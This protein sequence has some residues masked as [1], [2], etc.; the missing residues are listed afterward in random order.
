M[1]LG[2]DARVEDGPGLLV[3]REVCA[4]MRATVG[5]DFVAHRGYA[6]AAERGDCSFLETE[7][8]RHFAGEV[9]LYVDEPAPATA[10]RYARVSRTG[11][12]LRAPSGRLW[13][14]GVGA[15]SG[16]TPEEAPPLLDVEVPPGDCSVD[17]YVYTPHAMRLEEEGFPGEPPPSRW[18]APLHVSGCLVAVLVAAGG[19]GAAVLAWRGAAGAWEW[20]L[21][22]GAAL[23]LAWGLVYR[24]SGEAS[25]ERGREASLRRALSELPPIPRYAI[26]VRTG[27]IPPADAHGGGVRG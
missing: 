12:W 16:R 14:V 17:L 23:W 8:T 20:P 13:L 4:R 18:T 24:L 7:G 26:V 27:F 6:V 22:L 5:P 25:R 19:L 3:D 11:L 9:A 21:G 1:K 2:C 10:A 15:V